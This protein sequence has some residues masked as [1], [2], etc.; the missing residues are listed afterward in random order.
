MSYPQMLHNKWL[1]FPDTYRAEAIASIL[2]WIALGESGVVIGGSGSG[3][4][5]IA[6]YIASRSDVRRMHL[7]GPTKITCFSLLI[8]TAYPS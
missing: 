4:T 2:Q 1:E 7:P 6:G 8:S 5:N 3:K